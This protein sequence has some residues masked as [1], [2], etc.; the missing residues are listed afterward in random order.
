MVET[1]FPHTEVV[2]GATRGCLQFGTIRAF[3]LNYPD[4]V[5]GR[6]TTI[7]KRVYLFCSFATERQ[8]AD[9]GN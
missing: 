8:A 9:F 7:R 6:T 1:R 5:G 3:L 2:G 4:L